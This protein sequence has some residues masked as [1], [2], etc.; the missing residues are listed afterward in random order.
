MKYLE[1]EFKM[2]E[3]CFLREN[4][5]MASKVASLSKMASNYVTKL[6]DLLPTTQLASAVKHGQQTLEVQQSNHRL[7][8]IGRLSQELE[9][10]R[11]EVLYLEA[12]NAKLRESLLVQRQHDNA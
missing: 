7:E 5:V 8:Y 10:T 3:T 12:E 2:K 9:E 6:N 4:D 11:R 1:N